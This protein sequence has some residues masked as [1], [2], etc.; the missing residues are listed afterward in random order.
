[1]KLGTNTIST[2]KLG[3]NQVQ[4]VYLGTN[5]VWSAVDPDA[6]AFFDRVTTAGGTLSATEQTAIETLVSDL[7]DAGIWTKMKAIYPMVG[8]S[9]AAC[10]QNLK[11]SSF[12]GTFTAT[13]WT[14]ASTGVTPNG[15]SAYMD[16][17]LNPSVSL[18]TDNFSISYYSRTNSL[19]NTTT[20][21]TDIGSFSGSA[22]IGVFLYRPTLSPRGGGGGYAIEVGD[23]TIAS[24]R[25]FALV[26][27]TS[28]TSQKFSRNGTILATN[29]TLDTGARP[30]LTI[31]LGKANGFNNFANRQCAFAH[32]GDGLTDTEASNFYTAVQAFQTTLSRQV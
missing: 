3:T 28:T 14:F 8:A 15:T 13:G 24:S 17:G 27:R 21:P 5:E 2:V 6:Q 7:K 4:K 31:T 32:I 29:T 10:A 20:Y 18:S 22:G 26:T 9:A 12:T 16:T 25:Y 1:M 19:A 30:N 23:N 11:S